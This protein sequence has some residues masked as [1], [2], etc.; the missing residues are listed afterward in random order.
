MFGITLLYPTHY[1][2]PNP[3]PNPKSLN[4]IPNSNPIPNPNSNPNPYL[5]PNL[6]TVGCV[7]YSGVMPLKIFIVFAITQNAI[8]QEPIALSLRG[9]HQIKLE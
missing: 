3:N 8:S 7:G 1:P 4:L 2:N 6:K 5:S 9:F